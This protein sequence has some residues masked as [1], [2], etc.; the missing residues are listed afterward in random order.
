MHDRWPSSAD[1]SPQ[2]STRAPFVLTVRTDESARRLDVP[3]RHSCHL[4]DGRLRFCG[5]LR[6]A[7]EQNGDSRTLTLCTPMGYR[8]DVKKT[9]IDASATF[10]E[11][12]GMRPTETMM[13]NRCSRI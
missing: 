4:A 11:G 12:V 10:V 7:A 6:R 2:R 1:L 3:N 5:V 13:L 9:S 8:F